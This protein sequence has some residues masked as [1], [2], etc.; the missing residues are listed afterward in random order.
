[1]TACGAATD[2]ETFWINPV[3]GCIGHEEIQRCVAILYL[4]RE[5]RVSTE[6]VIHTGDCVAMFYEVF[7]VD[8]ILA[9]QLPCSAVYPDHQRYRSAR[10]GYVKVKRLTHM[11]VGDIRNV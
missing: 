7:D 1:M 2:D 8:P 11:A 5:L 3:R 9:A 4:G 6:P 10:F